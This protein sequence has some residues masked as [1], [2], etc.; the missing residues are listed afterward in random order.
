MLSAWNLEA[1]GWLSAGSNPL[2]MMLE[3]QWLL[4][5][6]LEWSPSCLPVQ[7]NR[8]CTQ[9]LIAGRNCCLFAWLIKSLASSFQTVSDR[10]FFSLCLQGQK[11]IMHYH[12]LKVLLFWVSSSC[13]WSLIYLFK[14]VKR[15]FQTGCCWNTVCSSADKFRNWVQVSVI[16]FSLLIVHL[17][18]LHG[19]LLQHCLEAPIGSMTEQNFTGAGY[20]KLW[21]VYG[22]SRQMNK[23]RGVKQL[24]QW[25]TEGEENLIFEFPLCSV[26]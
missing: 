6:R 9:E 23:G 7:S 4:L 1:G 13:F 21:N 16:W 14:E 11:I 3:P 22:Q 10:F 26:P 24:A 17:S 5:G 2:E 12:Y 25:I 18:V 20:L 15:S 8:M 19:L